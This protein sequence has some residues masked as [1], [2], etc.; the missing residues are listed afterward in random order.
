MH[1][2]RVFLTSYDALG[3]VFAC[4]PHTIPLFVTVNVLEGEYYLDL[5][6]FI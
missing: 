4:H 1:D 5:K 2:G 3:I 6:V